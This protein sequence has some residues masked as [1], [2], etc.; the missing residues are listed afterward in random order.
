M[1][2]A[3]SYVDNH[4]RPCVP[5]AKLSTIAL[6]ATQASRLRLSLNVDAVSYLYSGAVSIGDAVQAIERQLYSWATVKLYYAFFYLSRALLAAHGTALL[7]EGTKPFSWH[8]M[9]GITPTK[10]D[11]PTHKAVLSSFMATFPTSILL[12]QPIAATP[13]LSW[14]MY[15]REEA[16]YT[17]ARFSEP[18][19][20]GHFNVAAREGIR[21]ILTAYVCDS[22]YL[23]SFDPDHAMLALPVEAL[24]LAL[25]EFSARGGSLQFGTDDRQYLASLFFDKSGPLSEV[26]ALFK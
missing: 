4:I 12:S 19:A 5:G 6:S 15:R 13:A 9:A 7:Y 26:V 11:G 22:S 16:N 2:Q 17:S 24:K 8:C 3:Q 1:H 21:K 23:Y 14:L 10:R 18:T 20:P 25:K